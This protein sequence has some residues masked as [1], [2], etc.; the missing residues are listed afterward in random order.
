MTTASHE[1]G[2]VPFWVEGQTGPLLWIVTKDGSRVNLTGATANWVRVYRDLAGGEGSTVKEI[3]ALA[4]TDAANGEITVTIGAAD[5]NF[6]GPC[7]LQLKYTD[8]S[9]NPHLSLIHRGVIE[10]ALPAAS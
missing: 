2:A 1:S 3:T 4:L 5:L 10:A 9:A 6:S 8:A 7:R